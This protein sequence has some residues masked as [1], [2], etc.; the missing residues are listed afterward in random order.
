MRVVM[1]A[2][3][4]WLG[5]IAL[6]TVIFG[7]DEIKPE[8]QPTPIAPAVVIDA[9]PAPVIAEAN[10]LSVNG[11]NADAIALLESYVADHPQDAA[12]RDTLLAIRVRAKENEIRSLLADQAQIREQIVGDPDYEKMKAQADRDVQRRLDIVEYYVAK[13][14]FATAVE[15]CNAILKD[16]PHDGA[17]LCMKYRI[18]SFVVEREREELLKEQKYR[19]GE[20]INDVIRDNVFPRDKPKLLRTV[21]IFD[22]DLQDAERQKVRDRLQE[23]VTLTYNGTKVREV[24]EP[25]FALT[26]INYVILDSAL[27]D[28]TLTIKLVDESVET[29]LNTIAKLVSLTYN[30]TGGTVFISKAGSEVLVTEII[31]LQSGLTD[32]AGAVDLGGGATA[33]GAGGAAGAGGAPGAPGGN[34]NPAA[35]AAGGAAGG[36]GGAKSDLEKFLDKIPDIIVGWPAECRIYVDRKSN[37]V[38]VR[39]TPTTI[40]ELKRLLAAL[41]YHNVQVLIETRFIEVTEDAARDLGIDWSFQAIDARNNI[42]VSNGDVGGAA[43]GDPSA[44]AGLSPG[45]IGAGARSYVVPGVASEAT[46]LLTSIAL[47]SGLSARLRALEQ[48]GK[49]DTLSEP[50]ILALNNSIGTIALQRDIVYTKGYQSQ[51]VSVGASQNTGGVVTAG[52]T[53]TSLVPQQDKVQV[54]ITLAIRP[55]IARNSDIITLQVQPTVTD[56]IQ[57]VSAAVIGPTGSTANNSGSTT[58]PQISTR[59]LTATLHVQNGQTVALGGLT[60][61][62]DIKSEAGLPF[63]SRVP[64]LG[65]LF[66]RHS[67]ASDRRNLVIL[68]AAHIIDP[69]GAKLGADIQRLRDTARIVLPPEALAEINAKEAAEAK[70]RRA[71]APATSPSDAPAATDGP[72][73]KKSGR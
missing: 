57:L 48:K 44:I 6:T 40:A 58:L 73:W 3:R 41:D 19:R 63:V 7:A 25:L 38:Y 45:T 16:H 15:L 51:I 47:G 71:P 5:A 42:G 13:K 27:S 37:T 10:T 53:Q 50:K 14:D 68:V 39:S 61:E 23:K 2:V 62:A 69:G 60:Q 20:G 52:Q 32:V 9:S 26:G 67:R 36:G 12:A 1:S 28:E 49:A 8:P 66:Q 65:S 70:A 35:A 46:G 64:L 21:W 56:L 54:G 30:Y 29:A 43:R 72:A 55:S 18:L 59:K 34:I 11:K 31:R 4:V 24:I 22:E 33:G 17:V